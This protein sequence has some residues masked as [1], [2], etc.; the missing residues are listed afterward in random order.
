MAATYYGTQEKGGGKFASL[1]GT[2]ATQIFPGPDSNGNFQPYQQ[3]N[4]RQSIGLFVSAAGKGGFNLDYMFSPDG[5]T[6][7]LVGKQVA[8]ATVTVD[9]GTASYVNAAQLDIH[10]GWQFKVILYNSGSSSDF[11]WEY[12]LYSESGH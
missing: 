2:T 7:W 8:S 12:R 1:G 10:V 5:G 11:A 4:E 9:G 3:C 6:T